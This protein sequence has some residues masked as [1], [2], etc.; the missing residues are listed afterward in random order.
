MKK[1]LSSS[2]SSWTLYADGASRGNPGKAGVGFVVLRN[3]N[4]EKEEGYYLGHATN[5]QAEYL[6]CIAAITYIINSSLF[7]P[8]DTISIYADSLLM[9][10]QLLGEYKVKN[11]QLKFL[12]DHLKQLLRTISWN[13]FHVMREKNTRADMLANKGIDNEIVAPQFL[14]F[15]IDKLA[16]F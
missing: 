15:Y 4:V 6:A 10:K 7:H 2:F 5:N 16:R 8:H 13:A 14:Y 1:H 3:G 11:E 9:I 12:H